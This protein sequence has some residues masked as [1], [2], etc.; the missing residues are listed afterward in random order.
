[1]FKPLNLEEITTR[2]E[3]LPYWSA[4]RDWE[5]HLDSCPRCTDSLGDDDQTTDDLC[6]EGQIAWTGASAM[7]DHQRDVAPLN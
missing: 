4:W 2:I 1:M 6:F 7:L 3:T 5:D